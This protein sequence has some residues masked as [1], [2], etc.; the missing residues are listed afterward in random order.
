MTKESAPRPAH[1]SDLSLRPFWALAGLVLLLLCCMLAL[2]QAPIPN[3]LVPWAN[4]SAIDQLRFPIEVNAGRR[5]QGAPARLKSVFGLEDGKRLW[6]VGD[7]G[8]ILFTGDGGKKWEG[9]VSGSQASL[10]AVHFNSDG[11]RGWAVGDSGTILATGN[12]GQTWTPQVSSVDTKL[13]SVH[14][15]DDGLRG[16]AVGA[17]GTI[18]STKDAGQSWDPK[19]KAFPVDLLSVQFSGDGQR[20]LAS[21]SGGLVIRTSDGGLTWDPYYMTGGSGTILWS[22]HLNGDGERGWAVGTSGTI[23]RTDNGGQAWAMKPQPYGDKIHLASVHF[24]RDGQRGWAIGTGGIILSTRDGGEK[25]APQSSGVLDTLQSV[26]FNEDG[27]LG[28]TVGDGGVILSTLDGGQTWASQSSG[29]LDTLL[30][31]HLN[32]DD[33]RGWSVGNGGTILSTRDGGHTWSAQSSGVKT[34]LWSVHFNSDG[35]RGWAVG[36]GGKILSTADGGRTWSP[37]ESEVKVVLLSVHFNNDGLRG[38]TVGEGGTILYTGNGGKTWTP[39][40]S[41]G[42]VDLYSVHVNGDGQRGWAVGVGGTILS[43]LDGGKN[44]RNQPRTIE[45]TPDEGQSWKTLENFRKDLFSVHFSDGGQHGWAVGD[46]GTILSTEDGGTNW[47]IRPSKVQATLFSVHFSENRQRGWAVGVGGTILKT[48]NGGGS[49]TPVKITGVEAS[50]RSGSTLRSVWVSDTSPNKVWVVG[51]PPALQHTVN[52]GM[53]WSIDKWPLNYARYPAPWFWLGL[54]AVAACWW[55][56]LLPRSSDIAKGAA[57]MVTTDAQLSSAALDRL[58]F[59]RL[60]RGISRFLRNTAT[61]PPLTLAVSGDWGTGKSSL[62]ALVCEDMRR[63]GSR[64]VW[65]NAWH[66]QKDEQFLAALLQAVRAQALPSL[67]SAEGW[68]FRLRLL[69]L[70]SRKHYVIAILA[71]LAASALAGFMIM[72]DT[73]QWTRLSGWLNILGS[74]KDGKPSNTDVASWLAQLLSGLAVLVTLRKALTAFGA[75]PAVLLAPSVEKFKLSDASA[76]TDFRARFSKEFG[77]VTQCLPYRMLIVIDDLDRCKPEA[78]L[79]VME[80]VN[81]LVSSGRC[82]VMLGMATERVRAAIG[83]P[84]D[85]IAREMAD[86]APASSDT[87]EQ[88]R[89]RRRAYADAYLEKLINLEILVPGMDREASPSL[90][91]TDE[92]T[93]EPKRRALEARQALLRLW[94]VAVV[95]A[96]ACIGFYCGSQ[97]TL[98]EPAAR[99][100]VVGAA[101]LSPAPVASTAGP[102]PPPAPPAST[103]TLYPVPKVQ[104]GE[105]RATNRWAVGIPAVLMLIVCI[106]YGIFLLRSTLN[107]VRDSQRF[108]TALGIWMPLVYQKRRTPRGVK[109]FANRVRYLAMLQQPEVL[110]KS[111]WNEMVD[112]FY[113]LFGKGNQDPSRQQTDNAMSAVS[114]LAE[115]VIVG[116]GALHELYGDQWREV[117]TGIAGSESGPYAEILKDLAKSQERGDIDPWP[118]GDEQ[119][120]AFERSLKGSRVSESKSQIS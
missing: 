12:A 20:G 34:D 37:Q 82:F 120:K 81:F 89:E 10:W 30:S 91:R 53:T 8:A 79:E 69:W 77:E 46:G 105:D 55:W 68:V 72:H 59:G 83:L 7:G 119:L 66:H 100:P 65:F 94:P 39:Q 38:W 11:Q 92:P 63:H 99:T 97:W 93:K 44:W 21:G 9:Q 90:F 115:D 64:P 32:A 15:N 13:T 24:N 85:A 31:V 96:C 103:P 76:L 74:A 52:G 51:F 71:L 2:L 29:S 33:Q 116:L 104:P 112:W 49:W 40:L 28:W 36:V 26:H 27:Q 67:M 114:D 48:A 5:L 16:W 60:A 47:K 54:L 87:F 17:D 111:G 106:G 22:V 118:P 3:P 45:F 58:G 6:A 102:V 80:A 78:M 14:F 62:M 4:R 101:P 57:A 95:A 43:T 88:Q 107:H 18:L 84:L 73:E 19:R 41:R 25:W 98:P 56:A 109:R 86:P 110:D 50:Q 1:S 42:Q 61:E 113:G 75:D 23:L 108:V 70:R 35:R 117:I